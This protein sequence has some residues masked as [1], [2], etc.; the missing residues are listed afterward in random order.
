MK[1]VFELR[2]AMPWRIN[3]N[4]FLH[5]F[6]SLPRLLRMK[7]WYLINFSCCWWLY[8]HLWE[9]W[10]TVRPFIPHPHFFV[11]FIVEISL[12]ALIPLFMPGSVYSCSASWDNQL[13]LQWQQLRRICAGRIRWLSYFDNVVI[14]V[15]RCFVCVHTLIVT[16]GP[17]PFFKD[18]VFYLS[19]VR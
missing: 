3:V 12:C 2:L 7:V 16:C 11:C 6:I 4:A 9:F 15:H 19:K 8:P 13:L 17:N 10:K 5:L 14:L 1:A 18:L